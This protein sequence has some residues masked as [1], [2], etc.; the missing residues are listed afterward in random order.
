M[1]VPRNVP[2]FIARALPVLLL[3]MA[4]LPAAAHA[5]GRL[6]YRWTQANANGGWETRS[7]YDGGACPADQ[8]LRAAPSD[9]FPVTV[10]T[11]T[12]AAPAGTA[13][14]IAVIGDTGCRAKGN[15]Q[16]PCTDP[17]LWPFSAV[18]GDVRDAR[19]HLVLH[20]GDYLYRE[21]CNQYTS[22]CGDNWGAWNADFFAPA[23]A[24]LG[25]VPWVFVRGNHEDCTRG[26]DG[27]FVFLDPRPYSPAVGCREFTDPFAVQVAGLG[28][29]LIIDSAC[30]PSYSTC[31]S[32][33]TTVAE[34]ERQMGMLRAM[35]GPSPAWLMTHVPVWGVD[36]PGADSAGGARMQAALAAAGGAAA[37][38]ARTQFLLVSH[39]H[40]WEAITWVAAA[41]GQAQRPAVLIVGNSGT[42]LSP[43]PEKPAGTVLD[44]V[45]TRDLRMVNGVFGFVLMEKLG[46]AWRASLQPL[47]TSCIVQGTAARC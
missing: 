9:S 6:L 44:G 35:A 8:R 23:G 20:L 26:G 7:I 36:F 21:T 25:A 29:L 22:V 32:A 37:F 14:R 19:P 31:A 30:A 40:A 27:W 38:P 16:Q 34:Y 39:I 5:Q 42:E 43:V 2:P 41:A 11:R 47:N 4:A 13:G 46:D 33:D 24:L 3:A 28:K 1:R 45:A 18:A 12:A 17:A 10:C 15:D